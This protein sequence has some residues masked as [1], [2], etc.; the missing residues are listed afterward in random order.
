MSKCKISREGSVS[1]PVDSLLLRGTL[2]LVLCTV[3]LG[4][5]CFVI[6]LSWVHKL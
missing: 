4:F 2:H 3:I 1:S 5:C 6:L